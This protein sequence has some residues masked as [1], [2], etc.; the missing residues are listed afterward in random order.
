MFIKSRRWRNYILFYG[1][2]LCGVLSFFLSYPNNSIPWLA[3]LALVMGFTEVARHFE[4]NDYKK[5]VADQAITAELLMRESDSRRNESILI[6]EIGQSISS[7]LD[8]DTL[9]GVIMD[10]LKH[11]LDFDRGVV[12]LANSEK[13][14]SIYKAGY[15]VTQEQEDFLRKNE[16]HLDRPESRGPFVVA[17]REQKPYLVNDLSKIID[18]LSNR[19]K[20]FLILS[21]RVLS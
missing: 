3:F 9:L 13:N 12:L 7:M 10:I 11:R 20:E 14:R 1:F 15:G 16:F 5:Q 2:L 6:K 17:F 21:D 4:R 18:D 8:I 19:S